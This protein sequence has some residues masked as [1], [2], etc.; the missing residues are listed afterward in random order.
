M[1]DLQENIN[2][3]IKK[4]GKTQAFVASR[5]GINQGS[6]SERLSKKEK[7]KYQTI[8]DIADILGIPVIDIITYPDKY[9]KETPTCPKCEELRLEIKH[10]NEYIELLKHK[11]EKNE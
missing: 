8:S 10:L 2:E 1:V 3:I 5:L 6:L 11:Y 7:I 4:C 9:V